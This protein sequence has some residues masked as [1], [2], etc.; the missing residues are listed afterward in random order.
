MRCLLFSVILFSAC[1]SDYKTLTPISV[2][3]NCVVR[4]R[5]QSISTSWYTAGID[6]I[7]KHLSGLIFLKTMPDNS[8]R[9]VFMNEAGVTFFDFE[10]DS[11][12][13]FHVK[14]II[15]QFD[16]KPV[17]NVLR[18]D[19]ALLMGFPFERQLS[20]WKSGDKRYWGIKQSQSSNYFVTSNDCSVLEGVE[21]GS[22]RK[23]KVTI[24]VWGGNKQ[25]PDSI[26]IQ[27]HTFA[28]NI[29]LKKFEKN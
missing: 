17:L 18:D 28:M 12:H 4:F 21:S 25:L 16:R 26:R 9:V 27:H 19:F 8:N 5:P 3:N 6:V 15:P 23:R 2:D 10:F 1:A 24:N 7:G 22:N 14:Q 20:G 29:L 11:L 13:N